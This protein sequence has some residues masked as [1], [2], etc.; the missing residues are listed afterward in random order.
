MAKDVEILP[1]LDAI[2][3]RALEIFERQLRIALLD[4]GRF[5]VALAGGS[6]PKLLYQK[7]AQRSLPL[8]NIHLFWGDE[9]Y[10]PADHPESNHRMVREAWLDHSSIPAQNVHPMPTAANDPEADAHA[11]DVELQ[12]FFQLAAGEI[13][14]FDLVLL[15]M[16]DDGHTASL[17]PRTE[18][19]NVCDRSVT[20]G[21]KSGQPRL[22]LTIPVLNQARCVVFMVAGASKLTAL[23]QV[24]APESDPNQYPSRFVQPREQCYWLLDPTLRSATLD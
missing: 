16:G 6:T 12:Q 9:R 15:G 19:L 18:A 1:D 17:F 10:V 11:Y 20:T 8:N 21:V 22:T 14:T 3:Q 4:R 7:L 5:T 24:F 13:P 2:A 23:Q